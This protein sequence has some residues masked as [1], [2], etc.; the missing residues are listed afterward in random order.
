MDVL[1]IEKPQNLLILYEPIRQA[2]QTNLAIS[3]APTVDSCDKSIKV[4]SDLKWGGQTGARSL[5]IGLYV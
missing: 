1:K 3:K 5:E 4:Q 2:A